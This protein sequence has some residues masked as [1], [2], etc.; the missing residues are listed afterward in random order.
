MLSRVTAER[1]SHL[2]FGHEIRMDLAD[3]TQKESVYSLRKKS[4]HGSLD[5]IP[6][7]NLNGK[8]S[9]KEKKSKK[10][11]H[12]ISVVHTAAKEWT[13][14]SKIGY[15]NRKCKGPWTRYWA[16]LNKDTLYLYKTPEDTATVDA[17]ALPGY[18]VS[19]DVKT[20][21]KSRKLTFKLVHE[22]ERSTYFSAETE[23]DFHEW[24][25]MIDKASQ[26]ITVEGLNLE[27]GV[28]SEFD[29]T[30]AKDKE[31]LKKENQQDFQREL[32]KLQKK[33]LLQEL[34]ARNTGIVHKE[35]RPKSM[36]PMSFP[37][38]KEEIDQKYEKS[39][40]EEETKALKYQT[41][42]KRRRMSAQI[43]VDDLQK[44]MQ[45]EKR[46]GVCLSEEEY[47]AMEKRLQDLNNTLKK[48]ESDIAENKSHQT[49]MLESLKEKKE[50]ELKIVAQQ[51]RMKQY[52]KVAAEKALQEI[53]ETVAQVSP[54]ASEQ[55]TSQVTRR[56]TVSGQQMK[57]RTLPV[58]PAERS[59][60][61]IR[62]SLIS[63]LD[64]ESFSDKSTFRHSFPGHSNII[65][66]A[67]S[68]G[69]GDLSLTLT[70]KL[71]SKQTESSNQSSSESHVSLEETTHQE[72]TT[73]AET[74]VSTSQAEEVTQT[75][76]NSQTSKKDKPPIRTEVSAETLAEIEAFEKLSMEMLGH[77][78]F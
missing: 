24:I 27:T 35:Q 60:I 56:Q 40:E 42:L 20:A 68:S 72:S 8:K 29:E 31:V 25:F 21:F 75:A 69:N 70:S 51:H 58:I 77:Y 3:I 78:G 39:V 61:M 13:K 11:M 53:S 63:D 59:P 74:N 67:V 41:L 5:D 7:L 22:G 57:R 33:R 45:E 28:S 43:K 52:R 30:Q 23:S 1:F 12:P 71:S 19:T 4:L 15:L 10:K 6:G 66:K 65:E 76:E 54:M 46:K 48:V 49:N 64:S 17:M 18:K 38:T 32:V 2:S 73:V 37:A 55:I 36:P 47:A 34:L 16:V 9:K 44:K 14:A 62:K 26:K 50:L